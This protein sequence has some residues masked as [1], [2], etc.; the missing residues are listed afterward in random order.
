MKKYQT[1]DM[2]GFEPVLTL[3]EMPE[4]DQDIDTAFGYSYL[5]AI[6]FVGGTEATENPSVSIPST[7]TI[8]NS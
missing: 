6:R 4:N 7:A 8:P 5:P 1:T 3:A 2:T